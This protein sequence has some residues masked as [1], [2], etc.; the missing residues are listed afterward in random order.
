[1]FIRYNVFTFGWLLIVLLLTLTPGESMPRG[2]LWTNLLSFDKIAHFFVFCI[3]VFLMIIGFSKQYTFEKL[4]LNAVTYSVVFGILYGL[5][6]E[7]I[8]Y[9]IP[10]RAIEPLDILA[11]T[12]GCF[13]GL[14]IFY[15][16]YKF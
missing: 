4:R 11:N 16:I 7:I 2:G 12:I 9:F 14:G 15:L 1:M 13:I 3:L 6:I 10:G 5:L 8:Q